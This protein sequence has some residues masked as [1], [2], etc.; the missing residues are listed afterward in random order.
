MSDPTPEPAPQGAPKGKRAPAAASALPAPNA[1]DPRLDAV[2]RAFAR[3]DFAAAHEAL[4]APGN[5]TPPHAAVRAALRLDPAIPLTIL[6][7]LA[8]WAA[9]FFSTV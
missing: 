7:L 6:A 1:N 2:A 4:G 8:L 5:D 9:V 3:G